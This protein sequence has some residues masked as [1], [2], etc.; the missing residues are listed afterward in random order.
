MRSMANHLDLPHLL[1]TNTGHPACFVRKSPTPD[2]Y[3]LYQKTA[4][5][6]FGKTALF[7]IGNAVAPPSATS[8]I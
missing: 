7:I 1:P 8:L 4:V 5:P 3:K 6:F 2:A